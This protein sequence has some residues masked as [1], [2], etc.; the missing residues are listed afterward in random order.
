[1]AAKYHLVYMNAS[2]IHREEIE[3]ILTTEEI[4]EEEEEEEEEV[5]GSD[6]REDLGMN[7]KESGEKA[8]TSEMTPK[9]TVTS[10]TINNT[11]NNEIGSF[12]INEFTDTTLH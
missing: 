7:K 8:E 3:E 5:K 9:F 4:L 11:S 10:H 1:M 2:Q 6:V 12:Y